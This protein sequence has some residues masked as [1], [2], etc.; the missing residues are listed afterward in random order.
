MR[1]EGSERCGGGRAGGG[2]AARPRLV[3]HTSAIVAGFFGVRSRRVLDLWQRGR[4]IL[5][6]SAAVEARYADLAEGFEIWRADIENVLRQLAVSDAVLRI[7]APL[8]PGGFPEHPEDA[9]FLACALAAEAPLVCVDRH[10][11]AYAASHP[12][13]DVLTPAQFI[14]RYDASETSTRAARPPRR[15]PRRDAPPELRLL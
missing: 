6:T 4:V 15:R 10:L 11:L 7:A 1:P 12:A 5:C 9:D 13:V 2:E 8:A 14:E 3:L